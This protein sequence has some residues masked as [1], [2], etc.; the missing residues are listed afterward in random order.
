R[1]SPAGRGRGRGPAVRRRGAPGAGGRGGPSGVGRSVVAAG[2]PAVAAADRGGGGEGG[3]GHGAVPVRRVVGGRRGRRAPGP[4]GGVGG[5]VPPVDGPAAAGR[6]QRDV[7]PRLEAERRRPGAAVGAVGATRPVGV[8]G[9]PLEPPVPGVGGRPP[10]SPGPTPPGPAVP[11]HRRYVATGRPRRPG[12]AGRPG[13][14]GLHRPVGGV[15]RQG[16]P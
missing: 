12:A 15:R 2:G 7:D 1:P 9:G 11:V 8:D 10:D 3:G 14:P 4:S 16:G 13:W 5:P 6:P